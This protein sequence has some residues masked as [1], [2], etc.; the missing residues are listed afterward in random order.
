MQGISPR[1]AACRPRPCT[2]ACE[3]AYGAWACTLSKTA[4]RLVCPI[5]KREE[6]Q[7]ATGFAAAQAKDALLTAVDALQTETK[8]SG[9]SQPAGQGGVGCSRGLSKPGSASCAQVTQGQAVGRRRV[10]PIRRGGQHIR[11]ARSYHITSHHST[12][13]QDQGQDQDQMMSLL[14]LNHGAA[15]LH[16]HSTQPMGPEISHN[17]CISRNSC[18]RLPMQAWTPLRCRR[19]EADDAKPGPQAQAQAQAQSRDDDGLRQAGEEALRRSR[20]RSRVSRRRGGG[21]GGGGGRRRTR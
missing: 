12:S 8:R 2:H 21:G 14:Q 4:G 20:S 3:R 5:C 7:A 18:S 11:S 16:G 13:H 15:R 10:A 17:N 1:A 9:G 6:K 19:E